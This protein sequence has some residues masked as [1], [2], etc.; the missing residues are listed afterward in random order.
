MIDILIIEQPNQTQFSI[1]FIIQYTYQSFRDL[2]IIDAISQCYI[3]LA[4][5]RRLRSKE[6]VITSDSYILVVFTKLSVDNHLSIGSFVKGGMISYLSLNTQAIM[7]RG[8]RII[9]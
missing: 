9:T 4:I 6:N 2:Y 8:M 7:K 1:K 3:T 5:N